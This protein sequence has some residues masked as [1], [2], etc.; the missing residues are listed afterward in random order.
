M[1]EEVLKKLMTLGAA[2]A[3]VI[4][5][6]TPFVYMILTSVS[7]LAGFFS[8]ALPWVPTLAHYRSVMVSESLHFMAFLRNSIIVSAA[9]AVISVFCASPP[10]SAPARARCP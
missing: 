8:P 5:C 6:L 7:R 2:L 4:F 1:N 10:L 3:T 9:S